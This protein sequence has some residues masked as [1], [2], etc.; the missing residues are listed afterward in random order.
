MP[1]AIGLLCG[2]QSLSHTSLASAELRY[3]KSS[4]G[5]LGGSNISML[6]QPQANKGR[7]YELLASKA[8]LRHAW[9]RGSSDCQLNLPPG[10][11]QVYNAKPSQVMLTQHWK[12]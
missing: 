6:L 10:G 8:R 2:K 4:H 1:T 11:G 12:Y 3:L 9:P 5:C 7:R